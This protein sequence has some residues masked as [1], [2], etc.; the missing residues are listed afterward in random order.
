MNAYDEESPNTS[1]ES[2]TNHTSN[3]IEGSDQETLWVYNI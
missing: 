2:H 1:D 3:S